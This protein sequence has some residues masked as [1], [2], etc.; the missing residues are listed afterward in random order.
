MGQNKPKITN[1]LL[2]LLIV[3]QG[4]GQSLKAKLIDY[5]TNIAIADALILDENT[6]N[7]TY[8][9][10]DGN[11][12]I[13]LE[14]NQAIINLVI[15]H[16]LYSDYTAEVKSDKFEQSHVF[17]LIQNDNVNIDLSA[18]QVETNDD[19]SPDESEVYSILGSSKDILQQTIAFEF[20]IMRY[21]NRGISN[22]FDQ[23]GINGF[24]LN[25]ITNSQVPY[26]LISGQN[27]LSRYSETAFSFPEQNE[28]FG[29]AGNNQWVEIRLDNFRRG[30]TCNY[31]TSNRSYRNRIGVHYVNSNL[32]KDFYYMVGANR[33]W[34]Q[35]G[36]NPG[37]FYDAYG[38]YGGIQKNIRQNISMQALT[39][40][41]PVVRSRSAPV[42]NEV[43][44]LTGNTLYNPY[45]GYQVNQKRN[46]RMVNTR[47]PVI[48]LTLENRINSKVKDAYGIMFGKGRKSRSN[49]DWTNIRDPRPDYYQYLP[50]YEEDLNAKE[51]KILEW[52]RNSSISQMNWDYFYQTNYN[53]Y[54]TIYN[55]NGG[56][57]S[58]YG[59]R[60]Q[61]TLLD[62][63]N[64]P[65][66]LEVY[67]RR[68]IQFS[69]KKSLVLNL[70]FE[71]VNVHY[72]NRMLDLLGG[73]Y[74]LDHENFI[75]GDQN[76]NSQVVN[77]VIYKGDK[78]GQDYRINSTRVSFYQ[79]WSQRREKAAS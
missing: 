13:Q 46:S 64:D 36:G 4:L 9:D 45:W 11:F 27:L 62:N 31:S 78:F 21:R 73:D 30:L 20:S 14:K 71:N 68:R 59:R 48:L 5:R 58:I 24:L 37:T 34:A 49:I 18:L 54:E 10:Q 17:Y 33:R 52:Q 43:V 25:D 16:R 56:N 65:T 77:H 1:L 44:E 22:R 72:Y 76:S 61:Y 42:V 6:G 7:I 41:T 35:E 70:R 29:S 19:V 79:Q 40:F 63:H 12:I 32:K 3:T 15:K 57:D 66:E 28:D 69:H 38:I 75:E 55:I 50:S 47:V 53:S 67:L 39:F 26:Y 51:E 8:S 60:S 2:F 74:Y 23:F